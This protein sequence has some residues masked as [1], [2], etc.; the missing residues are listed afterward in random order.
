[1][2]EGVK[3]YVFDYIK[4]FYNKKLKHGSYIML[5]TDKI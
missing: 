5:I 2:R 1:M 4:M 3:T